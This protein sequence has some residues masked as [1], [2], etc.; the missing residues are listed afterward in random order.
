META[1][2]RSVRGSKTKSPGNINT[3]RQPRGKWR[4]HQQRVDADYLA[5]RVA[6]RHAGAPSKRN[7]TP[8]KSTN[9]INIPALISVIERVFR[10]AGIRF[11]RFV[12]DT[13]RSGGARTTGETFGKPIND[14]TRDEK[15]FWNLQPCPIDRADT[16]ETASG[17]DTGE[18]RI[19]MKF[20]RTMDSLGFHF[21]SPTN[22]F[23]QF[24]ELSIKSKEKNVRL[25]LR[26]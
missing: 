15:N 14:A 18:Q 8:P 1:L 5:S 20:H 13:P 9:S 3:G 17:N 19:D 16:P 6:T 24:S 2:A 12:P 7:A 25:I 11:P 4:R 21:P 10:A 22:S 23:E 26:H